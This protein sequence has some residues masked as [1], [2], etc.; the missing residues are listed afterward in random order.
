MSSIFRRPLL[1]S[2]LTVAAWLFSSNCLADEWIVG[3]KPV[4]VVSGADSG[5]QYVQLIVA[6]TV[7]NPAGC[8]NSD[9]YVTRT[10]TSEALSVALAAITTGKVINI[11]IRSTQGACDPSLKRPL[12]SAIAI[13][14]GN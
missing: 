6:Q 1:L 2:S 4:Q 9:T 11:F 8:V 7:N 14:N 12:F 5:G 13:G 10:F 3:L